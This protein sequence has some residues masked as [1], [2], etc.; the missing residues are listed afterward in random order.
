MQRRST[1]RFKLAALTLATMVGAAM[2]GCENQAKP[3]DLPPRQGTSGSS[4]GAGSK[5]DPAGGANGAPNPGASGRSGSGARRE[6][7]A[8]SSGQAGKSGGSSDGK[9]D[10][11]SRSG[12]KGAGRS[13]TQP[14]GEVGNK[15]GNKSGAKGDAGG[16]A[17]GEDPSDGSWGGAKSRSAYGSSSAANESMRKDGATRDGSAGGSRGARSGTRDATPRPSEPPRD[18][19]PRN[20]GARRAGVDGLGTPRRIDGPHAAWSIVLGTF[21]G[22]DHTEAARDAAAKLGER[23]PE[24]AGAT[25]R[26]TAQGSMLLWGQFAG[27]ED[28]SAQKEIRRIQ[29][30]EYKGARPFAS[31][32][33]V[34]PDP[35]RKPP[36][37]PNDLRNL[38]AQ[39]PRVDPLYTLQV[40]AWAD[41]DGSM[42]LEE[43][44][45]SA[46]GYAAELR[47]RGFEAWF[48]HDDDLKMS[49]VTVG[50]FGRDAYDPQSTL[51][52][53]E[54]EKLVKQFP[55]H[56]VNGTPLMLRVDPKN[57]KS[58]EVPQTCPLVE[59]PR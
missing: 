3:V 35:T 18:G 26:S 29:A 25:V 52:S 40:A 31:A 55:K 50:T 37:S 48:H 56:L 6:A 19:G 51:F 46:E 7:A 47:A 12:G 57:P 5:N 27:P 2:V 43:I 45:R 21:T 20:A 54:L 8:G 39:F 28:P 13:G 4:G 53:P 32:M 1:K 41:F 34:R 16:A 30:Y 11:N 15:G 49:V 14:G 23:I 33:I 58:A 42:S 38:R 22:P 36:T 59:V 24:F 9:G 10:G 44:R 17:G